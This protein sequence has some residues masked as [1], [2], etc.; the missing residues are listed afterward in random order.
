[1]VKSCEEC[2]LPIGGEGGST[3]FEYQGESF[4]HSCYVKMNPDLRCTSCGEAFVG[5]RKKCVDYMKKL[6]HEDCLNEYQATHFLC[7]KCKKAIAGK[8]RI[9]LDNESVCPRC[10]STSFRNKGGAQQGGDAGA[11]VAATA[12]SKCSASLE[13]ES[14]VTYDENSLCGGCFKA[15]LLEVCTRCHESINPESKHNIQKGEIVWHSQCFKCS[16]CRLPMTSRAKFGVFEGN[17]VCRRCH[18]DLTYGQPEIKKAC[19]GCQKEFALG[20]TDLEY[21][22]GY[23]HDKC[24]ICSFCKAS[25]GSRKFVAEDEHWLCQECFQGGHMQQGGAMRAMTDP[26]KISWKKAS[27]CCHDC[28]DSLD[29]RSYFIREGVNLCTECHA[30]KINVTA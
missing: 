27:P 9:I 30:K 28:F 20:D 19:N 12:C 24:L 5:R 2:R 10:Y 16:E 11:D 8:D 23:F 1:M 15:Y 29:S 22:G 26:S 14:G 13:G 6:W 4:C 17:I 18:E 25:L 3:A 7:S 21:G